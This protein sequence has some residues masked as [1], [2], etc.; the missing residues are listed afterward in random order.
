M[1]IKRFYIPCQVSEGLFNSEFY[2]MFSDSGAYVD[3]RQVKLRGTL[4]PN[5]TTPGYVLAYLVEEQDDS[6]LVEV[7][8]EPVVGGLRAW[9]SKEELQAA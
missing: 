9:V 8:G 3:A 4:T 7:S 1:D 2:I 6:A 5:T